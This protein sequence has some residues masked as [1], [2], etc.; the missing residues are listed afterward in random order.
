MVDR[1]FLMSL[2]VTP[3]E[4]LIGATSGTKGVDSSYSCL[5]DNTFSSVLC[6][7]LPAKAPRTVCGVR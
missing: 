7:V 1:L 4:V 2:E 5:F 3:A 6:R